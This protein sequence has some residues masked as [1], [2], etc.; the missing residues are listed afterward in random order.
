M[1]SPGKTFDSSGKFMS[2]VELLNHLGALEPRLWLDNAFSTAGS[3]FNDVRGGKGLRTRDDG[4]DFVGWIIGV[5]AVI[6]LLIA[7]VFAIPASGSAR[8]ERK[9]RRRSRRDA[10]P[11]HRQG[12]Q[13]PG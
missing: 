8:V 11:Q 13:R 6:V 3:G 5:V 7:F 10:A 12:E 4:V 9:R 2:Y 1:P